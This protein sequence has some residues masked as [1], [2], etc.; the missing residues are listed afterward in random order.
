M[1]GALYLAAFPNGGPNNE[2]VCCS[3]QGLE[4][5]VELA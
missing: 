2:L 5:R 1:I 4:R 3:V